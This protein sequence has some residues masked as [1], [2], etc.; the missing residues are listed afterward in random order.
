MRYEAIIEK[1]HHIY[2][3]D[4]DR[5]EDYRDEELDDMISRHFERQGIAGFKIEDIKLQI[6]GRFLKENK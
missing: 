4:S 6:I 1:H 3:S 2:S 5:I